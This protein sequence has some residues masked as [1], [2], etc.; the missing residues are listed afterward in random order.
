LGEPLVGFLD[1]SP[2][3]DERRPHATLMTN[4]E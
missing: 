3:M 1:Q 4:E 2:L